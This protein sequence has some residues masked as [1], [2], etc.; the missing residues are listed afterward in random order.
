MDAAYGLSDEPMSDLEGLQGGSCL[1]RQLALLLARGSGLD[2]LAI[3][4]AS[5]V[6]TGAER[7]VDPRQA[8]SGPAVRIRSTS[9]RSMRVQRYGGSWRPHGRRLNSVGLMRGVVLELL[10]ELVCRGEQAID[11]WQPHNTR[12]E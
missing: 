2:L 10:G 6:P 11:R 4:L 5:R 8:L 3:S 9:L 1:P 12:A 7:V